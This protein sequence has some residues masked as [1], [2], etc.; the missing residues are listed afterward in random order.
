MTN[1]QVFEEV[2]AICRETFNNPG[3]KVEPSTSAKEVENWDSMTN[4]LLIDALEKKFDMVFSLDD[5]MD[6]Q[7]VGDLCKIITQAKK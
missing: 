3:L 2:V 6:A 7:N 5:I 1:E 4:L